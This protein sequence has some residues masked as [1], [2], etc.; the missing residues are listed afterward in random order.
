MY[1]NMIVYWLTSNH[2]LLISRNLSAFI[3]KMARNQSSSILDI[4]YNL[5]YWPSCFS[6]A[7]FEANTLKT[8][9][10]SETLQAVNATDEKLTII[11]VF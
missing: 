7:M 3:L 9:I 4:T 1:F 5:P 2:I 10:F 11:T 8:F 6:I